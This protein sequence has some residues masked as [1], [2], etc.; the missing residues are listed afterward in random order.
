MQQHS[1]P[2][3][4]DRKGRIT[5]SGCLFFLEFSIVLVTKTKDT[6][7][8]SGLVLFYALHRGLHPP[9][10]SCRPFRPDFQFPIHENSYSI[11]LNF[12]PDILNHK[13]AW[14]VWQNQ[15]YSNSVSGYKLPVLM[16]RYSAF[17]GVNLSTAI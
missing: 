14:A 13:I 10:I 17:L 5:W 16:S 4:G 12:K 3:R 1:Q 15:C 6:A 9:A 7:S 8:P 11:G 2:R